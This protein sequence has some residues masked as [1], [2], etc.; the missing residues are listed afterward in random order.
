MVQ[1]LN[2]GEDTNKEVKHVLALDTDK[3]VK[4]VLA[5]ETASSIPDGLFLHLRNNP[6]LLCRRDSTCPTGS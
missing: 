5:L 3:E 6:A 2:H 1:S 4:Y